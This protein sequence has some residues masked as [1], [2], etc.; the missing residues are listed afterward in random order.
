M[1]LSILTTH[2]KTPKVFC[3]TF[4]VH[5][6]KQHTLFYFTVNK[7]II[8]AHKDAKATKFRKKI[9]KK[10]FLICFFFLFLRYYEKVQ[11]SKRNKGNCK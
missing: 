8:F 1:F 9:N 11:I 2:N 10:A 3:L 5:I 7:T 6:T 4:G